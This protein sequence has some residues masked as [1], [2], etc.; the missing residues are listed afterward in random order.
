MRLCAS[1]MLLFTITISC[2]RKNTP[3]TNFAQLTI[4][5]QKFEFDSLKAVFDTSAWGMT[6]NFGIY[7]RASHSWMVW[8]TTS[9]SRWINGIYEYP[10][11]LYPPARSVEFLQLQTYLNW[12]PGTYALQYTTLNTI[13]T[14]TIDQSENGRMHGTFSGKIFCYTCNPYGDEIHLT[15]GEFE[16]PYTYR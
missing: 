2:S 7:N 9:S 1:L 3:R 10:G 11:H 15:D 13:F 6:G 12:V 14:I 4:G 16:M 8:E 5:G